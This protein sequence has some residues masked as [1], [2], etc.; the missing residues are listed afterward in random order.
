MSMC[1]DTDTYRG[2]ELYSAK[3][4]NSL[5]EFFTCLN[6][7]TCYVILR[8]FESLDRDVL[9]SDH[10]DI[11]ILCSDRDKLLS[12]S[13]SYPRRH[14]RDL[15]HRFIIVLNKKIDVDIR[16]VGDGYYDS[17]WEKDILRNRIFYNQ[18][19]YVPS[20]IDYFYSLL[21]HVLIQKNKVSDDYIQKLDK[22]AYDINVSE[23]N[24]MNVTT[25]QNFMRQKYYFYT[26]PES[27]YT[28]ANFEGVDKLLIKRDFRK[29]Y[30]RRYIKT[31]SFIIRILKRLLLWEKK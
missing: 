21:Y 11:D 22:L 30:V 10:P 15:V 2:S 3:C 4:W 8:N 29:E 17:T 19:F 23:K 28:I 5:D 27:P 25:L 12:I 16:C 9:I 20:K 6:E 7:S 31:R 13:R 18:R 1:K 14:I 26:Y 24:F